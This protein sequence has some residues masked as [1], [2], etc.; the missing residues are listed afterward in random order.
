MSRLAVKVVAGA[1]ALV[2]MGCGGALAFIYSGIYD[3][4]ATTPH[5]P[6][7]GWAMHETYE[8]ST[9]R[10]VAGLQ[11]PENLETPEAVQAGARFYKDNCVVCHGAPGIAASPAAQGLNPEAPLLLKATRKNNPAKM[12]WVIKTG[13]RMTGMPAFGKSTPDETLWQVAAFLHKS[14]GISNADFAALSAR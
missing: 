6:L 8:R 5:D 14:R 3:V 10:A 9:D 11:A 12:F 13:V 2:V 4:T 7:V 1:A